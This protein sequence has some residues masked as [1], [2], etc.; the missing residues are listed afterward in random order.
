LG[1]LPLVIGMPVI[2]TTNFDVENGIVNGCVGTLESIR[3]WVDSDGR[4]HAVS[5]V[6]RSNEI[7]GVALP[8]LNVNEAVAIEDEKEV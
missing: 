4:R 5:A 2:I 6:V 8:H 1:K 3:Y 7:D